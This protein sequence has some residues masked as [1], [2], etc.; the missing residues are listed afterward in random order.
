VSA[1]T[2]DVIEE[3]IGGLSTRLVGPRRAKRD[4]IGEARDG[5]VDAVDAYVDA[6]LTPAEAASRAVADFGRYPQVVPSFQTEL[7]ALQGRRTA[8]LVA[9]SMPT[10]MMLSRLMWTGGP[11]SGP[12]PSHYMVLAHAFDVL[13]VTA[14]IMAALTL[15]GYGWGSRYLPAERV[16]AAVLLTR[17]MGI[18]VL[19]FVVAEALAGIAIYAWSVHTWPGLATWPP[20]LVGGLVLPPFLFG[21]AR[22]AL[23]CLRVS[24]PGLRPALR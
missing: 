2:P 13:Q 4:L 15:L 21:V 5:L 22:S 10:A 7:A 24:A 1:T 14:A 9:I 17:L 16:P 3:Y 11:S 6:G 8:L 18:G 23:R 12:A 19:T 20:M